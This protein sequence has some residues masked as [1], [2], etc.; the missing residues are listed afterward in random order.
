MMKQ[1]NASAT[2]EREIVQLDVKTAFLNAIVHE[3]IYIGIP[4]GMKIDNKNNK[5]VLK[6][7]KALY[8]IKQAPR[9]WN[10]NI[11]NYLL[12]VGFT[13][14]KKD[15]C[16]YIKIS[17]NNN[18]IILGL[19]VD[20][21]VVSYVRSDKQEWNNI[22]KS[23]MSKYEI[24]DMGSVSSILGVMVRV[25]T[26]NNIYIHQHKYIKD[27]LQ[28]FNMNAC[29]T[30]NVPGD[31]NVMLDGNNE[32]VD[33]SL[34]RSMVGA[35]MYMSL[36][37]RPDITHAV[38]ICSRF[39]SSPTVTHLQ[40]IKKIFRYLHGSIEYGLLYNNNNNGNKVVVTAYSDADWGGDKYDM[41]ST[42][43][44]CCY[45]NNNL[46]S[47]N[48][49]KQTTVALSSAEAEL[50]ALNEAA[51]EVV[52]VSSILEEMHYIVKKPMQIMV[53]N[54]SAIK[55]A[56]NDIEHDRTKHINIKY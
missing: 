15:P 52:W 38:N 5:T 10:I 22:K 18:S 56:H 46:I 45:V 39:M 43:G 1:Y 37:T 40:A 30:C 21:I 19:F 42:S 4:Q 13:P 26:N 6:L 29:K 47:W 35:L 8:G 36:Y 20:D 53:D 12:T 27:K 31:A 48:T 14:C 17:K 51:K 9:E 28:L 54:Q 49:R 41:K 16:I 50:I 33:S 34:Y 11:N 7:N 32:S 44:Y 55:I 3:D 24:S 2:E 23:L 25:G